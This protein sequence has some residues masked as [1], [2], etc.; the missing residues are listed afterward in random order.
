[1]PIFFHCISIIYLLYYSY[2]DVIIMADPEYPSDSEK[3]N[4]D[5]AAGDA[6]KV[7]RPKAEPTEP[8]EKGV[9]KEALQRV[10]QR[11][12]DAVAS[13]REFIGGPLNGSTEKQAGDA[14]KPAGDATKPTVDDKTPAGGI[15]QGVKN[16]VNFTE[17]A[18]YDTAAATVDATAH[19]GDDLFLTE[20]DGQNFD[21]MPDDQAKEQADID[22]L[23]E[24][25][26]TNYMFIADDGTAIYITPDG[27][28]LSEYDIRKRHDPK[29][30]KWAA[31][32]KKEAIMN[33]QIPD[34]ENWKRQKF[35][36]KT[37]AERVKIYGKSIL[38][39]I[40]NINN[41]RG[42]FH[43]DRA[44][45]QAIAGF[46]NF[47][48][49]VLS[50]SPMSAASAMFYG[51]LD[52]MSALG[53][54][55]GSIIDQLAK[56]YGYPSLKGQNL[57]GLDRW[58]KYGLDGMKAKFHEKELTARR[59]NAAK[60]MA[61][62]YK[63]LDNLVDFNGLVKDEAS[64]FEEPGKGN[65]IMRYYTLGALQKIYSSD[66]YT[67][68]Q[69][70]ALWK[71]F[72]LDLSKKEDRAKF[73]IK[74]GDEGY[75][76]VL[77]VAKYL[78]NQAA[79]GFI[80]P[81]QGFTDQEMVDN[82]ERMLTGA[83]KLK[84]P[85]S[86]FLNISE[87]NLTK[88]RTALQ[89]RLDFI[90]E[91][92]AASERGYWYQH[93][94]HGERVLDKDG[95]PIVVK[96][97][98]TPLQ[99][100][101]LMDTRQMLNERLTNM[102]QQ[103]PKLL[104][105]IKDYQKAVQ[106]AY[107]K[108]QTKA[109]QRQKEL[110][111]YQKNW[112]NESGA[113]QLLFGRD[114]VPADDSIRHLT[115]DGEDVQ[116]PNTYR[117][118]AVTKLQ[119]E[120]IS[121]RL[122][123]GAENT[124][125]YASM[126]NA[127]VS[128]RAF[129]DYTKKV[130]WLKSQGHDEEIPDLTKEYKEIFKT[131]QWRAG[132]NPITK[133]NDYFDDFASWKK[134]MEKKWAPEEEKPEE[135]LDDPFLEHKDYL[136][137][138]GLKPSKANGRYVGEDYYG[139]PVLYGN[140]TETNILTNGTDTNGV[141]GAW[142]D[143]NSRYHKN[144]SSLTDEEFGHLLVLDAIKCWELR[145]HAVDDVVNSAIKMYPTLL[146]TQAKIDRFTDFISNKYLGA[147]SD[148]KN[149]AWAKYRPEDLK[150]MVE[151]RQRIYD[152][153]AA[154][155]TAEGWSRAPSD[156][157]KR[158][159]F[160]EVANREALIYAT[161][162][163]P[164]IED[165]ED[166]PKWLREYSQ[167]LNDAILAG[168]EDDKNQLYGKLGR[169]NELRELMKPGSWTN[170][171]S[172]EGSDPQSSEKLVQACID[173][174][175]RRAKLLDE[176]LPSKDSNGKS[177]PGNGDE[178]IKL[179]RDLRFAVSNKLYDGIQGTGPESEAIISLLG[180]DTFT[181]RANTLYDVV[182]AQ[183]KSQFEAAEKAGDA[184]IKQKMK[185][186]IEAEIDRKCNRA[187]MGMIMRTVS[188]CINDPFDKPK[189][190]KDGKKDPDKEAKEEAS[191]GQNSDAKKQ[192]NAG[193]L[194]KIDETHGRPVGLNE[195]ISD[196]LYNVLL[197]LDDTKKQDHVQLMYGLPT[198]KGDKRDF[199]RDSQ[200]QFLSRLVSKINEV[201]KTDP[202]LA[203]QM[204]N[205][206][207]MLQ[208][209]A[210][211]KTNTDI[212]SMDF[213]HVADW[214]GFVKYIADPTKCPP[215]KLNDAIFIASAQAQF[216]LLPIKSEISTTDDNSDNG[217]VKIVLR[218]KNGQY[219]SL[220][221]DQTEELFK[222]LGLGA[223]FSDTNP[224]GDDEGDPKGDD[225]GDP[226][227]DDEGDPKGDDEGDPKGDG[228]GDPKGDGEGDPVEE[229]EEPVEEEADGSEEESREK[230]DIFKSTLRGTD[231]PEA[232]AETVSLDDTN[233][234]EYA[235][236]H[237]GGIEDLKRCL[238]P[239]GA[240]TAD[241]IGARVQKYLEEHCSIPTDNTFP[242]I[243]IQL[244]PEDKCTTYC[245]MFGD[246][247]FDVGKYITDPEYRERMNLLC[248]FSKENAKRIF[249]LPADY[250]VKD[251]GLEKGQKKLC[252]A[253]LDRF[254]F[255]Q[256][257]KKGEK[258]Y[259]GDSVSQ[260]VLKYA[261]EQRESL[262]KV[263]ESVGGLKNALN[264]A[265]LEVGDKPTQFMTL[266]DYTDYAEELS[267]KPAV[268]STITAILTGRSSVLQ[269]NLDYLT[270]SMS[271]LAS[272]NV[273]GACD[274]LFTEH[275]IDWAPNDAKSI[276]RARRIV[277]YLKTNKIED[278][279]DNLLAI[280]RKCNDKPESWKFTAEE[281][282]TIF[283]LDELHPERLVTEIKTQL[284]SKTGP[285]GKDTVAQVNR[286]MD[287]IESRWALCDELGEEDLKKLTKQ[288]KAGTGDAK[289][290]CFSYELF[291]L[292]P[293]QEERFDPEAHRYKGVT[294]Q[295]PIGLKL[296]GRSKNP[297][298]NPLAKAIYDDI[299]KEAKPLLDAQANLK[300]VKEVQEKAYTIMDSL[301]RVLLWG[302]EGEN[303][304][305]VRNESKEHNTKKRD[306]KKQEKEQKIK[307]NL[308]IGE[309][310]WNSL[311]GA[312]SLVGTILGL[313]NMDKSRRDSMGVGAEYIGTKLQQ[314]Q[315]A[316][317]VLTHVVGDD[318]M[319]MVSLTLGNERDINYKDPI[320]RECG[321]LLA[322]CCILDS[323]IN[324]AAGQFDPD[325]E[326][327]LY[328]KFLDQFNIGFN[329]NEKEDRFGDGG[330]EQFRENVAEW[331]NENLKGV[332]VWDPDTK[333]FSI[334]FTKYMRAL[335]DLYGGIFDGPTMGSRLYFQVRDNES[336]PHLVHKEF[337]KP[338]E[339]IISSMIDPENP[340]GLSLEPGEKPVGIQKWIYK[341][342]RVIDD[343]ETE[344][345][346]IELRRMPL[347]EEG[348]LFANVLNE[349]R[350]KSTK[351]SGH[352]SVGEILQDEVLKYYPKYA[353]DVIR[354]MNTPGTN[355]IDALLAGG[356][357][358]DPNVTSVGEAIL[359]YVQDPQ[360]KALFP[361]AVLGSILPVPCITY[362]QRGRTGLQTI[363]AV[364][365][366][367][368]VNKDGT[369]RLGSE[370]KEFWELICNKINAGDADNK[371]G[372]WD[373][374]DPD[375]YVISDP[376]LIS[377][378]LFEQQNAKLP[379]AFI[380][381]G[382]K[383]SPDRIYAMENAVFKQILTEYNETRAPAK[384][385]TTYLR[386]MCSDD[387]D[388]EVDGKT[389]SLGEY[390]SSLKDESLS[391]P[392]ERWKSLSKV[393]STKDKKRN[394]AWL[395]DLTYLPD[396]FPDKVAVSGFDE[397][398]QK[399]AEALISAHVSCRDSMLRTLF[400]LKVSQV[401][402]RD[403][404]GK[405]TDTEVTLIPKKA[406]NAGVG[407]Y[408]DGYSI[409]TIPDD[410]VVKDLIVNQM[411][412]TMMVPWA[413]MNDRHN[414]IPDDRTTKNFET[415]GEQLSDA[416]KQP[417]SQNLVIPTS[418]PA[419]TFMIGVD[420]GVAYTLTSNRSKKDLEWIPFD[421]ASNDTRVSGTSGRVY[422]RKVE[423]GKFKDVSIS[424]NADMFWNFGAYISQDN[425]SGRDLG[426][427]KSVAQALD[428]LNQSKQLVR[429]RK[430]KY[431]KSP[432]IICNQYQ[433]SLGNDTLIIPY[434][435]DL[436]RIC[437]KLDESPQDR[438]SKT[439]LSTLAWDLV[440][441]GRNTRKSDDDP[442]TI[443]S[444]AAP[445]SNIASITLKNGDEEITL[446]GRKG[447]IRMTL[448]WDDDKKTYIPTE[449]GDYVTFVD[450]SAAAKE[451]EKKEEDTPT[452]P[453]TPV[454]DPSEGHVN[455]ST[456]PQ[457]QQ[458]EKVSES[459]AAKETEKK[460]EGQTQSKDANGSTDKNSL[461]YPNDDG[462]WRDTTLPFSERRETLQKL[463][464]AAEKDFRNNPT[465]RT[466]DRW[467]MYQDEFA[468]L[469]CEKWAET[470]NKSPAED[471][472]S[473][474]NADKQW[475]RMSDEDKI[476][477]CKH[478]LMTDDYSR[479][480]DTNL[481]L[482]ERAKIAWKLGFAA[483]YL[484][485]DVEDK[486]VQKDLQ[487]KANALANY[488]QDCT[489]QICRQAG[490][491]PYSR[492][493]EFEI[494]ACQELIFKH[495]LPVG[496]ALAVPDLTLG[497]EVSDPQPQQPPVTQNI[498]GDGKKQEEAHDDENEDN[499]IQNYPKIETVKDSDFKPWAEK[500]M[501]DLFNVVDIE[502]YFES[503]NADSD[504]KKIA[505]A[506]DLYRA[507]EFVL[508][509]IHDVRVNGKQ[510]NE[511]WVESSLVRAKVKYQKLL[512]GKIDLYKWEI[513]PED[514]EFVRIPTK[515]AKSVPS[516]LKLRPKTAIRK[517]LRPKV[518]KKILRAKP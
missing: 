427:A 309:K 14:N 322:I 140:S 242:T 132:A 133:G 131:H 325:F 24:D 464:E 306:Q 422:L 484:G 462:R 81:A 177:I 165:K 73:P 295:L 307:S 122:Q 396:D 72:S 489:D 29:L 469:T 392:K 352:G 387:V 454:T 332:V 504:E 189:K 340:L 63:D 149:K 410:F 434:H 501:G 257:N 485:H 143:L 57:F 296:S 197:D 407:D 505:A 99:R 164:T 30:E 41:E 293:E 269:K 166:V 351:I 71:I 43:I 313:R 346:H 423:N 205:Y 448:E 248:G 271:N 430:N 74:P 378:A 356:T 66:K 246:E 241:L 361:N 109:A 75:D 436:K 399:V 494:A 15:V 124:P 87:E 225:E 6:K 439:F 330:K 424:Q 226:K 348:G 206:A 366:L 179:K 455:G 178:R 373:K 88:Y 452:T 141:H 360:N 39:G 108:S 337:I 507:S 264:L 155:L 18:L 13:A 291:D 69:K 172:I 290:G 146:N 212:L 278:L 2:L 440:K 28:K 192:D 358:D 127:D 442:T 415:E 349:Q 104:K 502:G 480:Q 215:E 53:D 98:C 390:L 44:V 342:T 227:G 208:I 173:E 499:E 91:Q 222:L 262:A 350:M 451:T 210:N 433:I 97:N 102:D 113:Y 479:L 235:A 355:P 245:K 379:D 420:S 345:S 182:K 27:E 280:V 209:I 95:K 175:I 389:V 516:C 84:S 36:E 252:N 426:G 334:D 100:R 116:I 60:V 267:G 375:H 216:G 213:D 68:A 468:N 404:L 368:K 496:V 45:D 170:L 61:K 260:I 22:G 450:D 409:C 336:R 135:D 16:A 421:M 413:L 398:S 254:W 55:T 101:C 428:T 187:L 369:G 388:V 17:E 512:G 218:L 204:F 86:A 224:G 58:A 186:K 65:N 371:K 46:Q 383:L 441:Y 214:E 107:K 308:E 161:K 232:F 514:N 445:Q 310:T 414:Q 465:S 418:D 274:T 367:P 119:A 401:E 220:G 148:M 385:K 128:I 270:T 234:E 83:G 320:A 506:Y 229:P 188:Q 456:G 249:V 312:R 111:D 4:V 191:E 403:E 417:V 25:K 408:E 483:N 511:K 79:P 250:N 129:S 93:D 478:E 467:E 11:G 145:R 363:N 168:N 38:A 142:T 380:D 444:S 70:M 305:Q 453:E 288:E 153:N 518:K 276:G 266:D 126:F 509:H 32:L 354:R 9:V 381:S 294:R 503:V 90:D 382:L 508:Q 240:A 243:P 319:P 475:R 497:E 517:S 5:T 151:K 139:G 125:E 180:G 493:N 34:E 335:P 112:D 437:D 56:E 202:D 400:Y 147:G 49:A 176:F 171:P 482:V 12:I 339:Q 236:L 54:A 283:D 1:M 21:A 476:E 317:M 138:L 347:F 163:D 103:A 255:N 67:S 195:F 261:Q 198:F 244:V 500:I 105:N 359:D 365:G 196:E 19:L 386:A 76:V 259:N 458:E 299:E 353:E 35:L 364:E 150:E 162:A 316:K 481:S 185:Q 167:R 184:T 237:T 211:T 31:D 435:E 96:Y 156:E 78:R 488:Y 203:K 247:K 160:I 77:D 258:P 51:S 374:D 429:E 272:N 287:I 412:Q 201:N 207:R 459:A 314:D 513:D 157:N 275:D 268:I 477:W 256:A 394:P 33:G 515:I 239:S 333:K 324:G 120:M 321:E 411:S 397:N 20:A 323:N 384:R 357:N 253:N 42:G 230:N 106:D 327:G 137:S 136:G 286:L 328:K 8:I 64:A 463:V 40:L 466:K 376:L 52:N 457:G 432:S 289:I 123:D 318:L 393:F 326:S 80:P 510:M 110:E 425:N 341:E 315:H 217:A 491:N 298:L 446:T 263:L 154:E 115:I 391:L 331:V 117:T 285:K 304:T 265:P 487:D 62:W 200:E 281:I 92:L 26:R 238:D 447:G 443:T 47:L 284:S 472:K 228:E 495:G 7:L 498:A 370:Y 362:L 405:Y 233:L 372:G 473:T 419:D 48:N 183:Y 470:Q 492:N 158:K 50:G 251:A 416:E 406:V 301:N 181:Q 82:F 159:H 311:T 277:Q 37:K 303:R 169:L 114:H 89:S 279:P 193:R 302:A 121:L 329:T 219:V 221:Q 338:K 130:Q 402:K 23:G 118:T 395:S 438:L 490:F 85:E 144:K 461:V 449:W 474:E 152:P 231:L 190:K 3:D 431:G 94:E 59:D 282:K 344:H 174:C 486:D 377:L 343:P 471:D 292:T 300:K 194:Y 223:R 297:Y 10:V 273:F 460:E 134:E 199:T